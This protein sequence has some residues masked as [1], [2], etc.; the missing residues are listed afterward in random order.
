MTDIE[1]IAWAAQRGVAVPQFLLDRVGRQLA[2]TTPDAMTVSG[3]RSSCGGICGSLSPQP[4]AVPADR[5]DKLRV[6]LLSAQSKCRGITHW[7]NL[8]SLGLIQPEAATWTPE[9]G[10]SVPLAGL[11]SLYHSPPRQPPAPPPRIA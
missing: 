1:K 9:A 2:A 7:F 4:N 11:E 5:D 3:K 6:V 8:F 10:L